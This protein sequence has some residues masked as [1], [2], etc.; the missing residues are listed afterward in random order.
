MPRRPASTE[1]NDPKGRAAALGS[2]FSTASLGALPKASVDLPV[3]FRLAMVPGPFNVTAKGN[4]CTAGD[5]FPELEGLANAFDAG[6]VDK[7]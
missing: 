1:D 3:T 7:S 5:S 2:S 4:G 6:N